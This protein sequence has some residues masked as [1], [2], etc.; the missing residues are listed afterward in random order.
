MPAVKPR[1]DGAKSTASGSYGIDAAKTNE[2]HHASSE[3]IG[4]SPDEI[5]LSSGEISLDQNN[6]RDQCISTDCSIHHASSTIRYFKVQ[7]LSIILLATLWLY[8][9]LFLHML[10]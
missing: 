1:K 10:N 2:F 6:G 8:F 5:L 4:S 7:V 3:S 9:G